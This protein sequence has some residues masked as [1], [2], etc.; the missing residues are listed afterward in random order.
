M[1]A[2]ATAGLACRLLALYFAVNLVM[3]LPNMVA[4]SL[5][6][7]SMTSAPLNGSMLFALTLLGIGIL[8]QI[9]VVFSLWYGAPHLAKRLAL[10]TSQES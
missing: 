10:E 9:V 5:L 7:L 2:H 6:P 3:S 1:N 8:T 4:A